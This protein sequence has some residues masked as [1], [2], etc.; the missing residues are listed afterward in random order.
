MIHTAGDFNQKLP[1]SRRLPY[2]DVH[3]HSRLKREWETD[4][5]GLRVRGVFHYQFQSQS[6]ACVHPSC[7][8]LTS[9]LKNK[10]ES[11]E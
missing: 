6:Q 10:K 9:L 4:S 1:V 7:H 2:S 11:R 5:A 3:E 8:S